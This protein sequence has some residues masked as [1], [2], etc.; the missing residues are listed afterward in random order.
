M[1]HV[2]EWKCCIS[3]KIALKFVQKVRLTNSK[4]W[5]SS[6]MHICVT[7]PQCVNLVGLQH[8]W[9]TRSWIPSGRIN[10]CWW[11]FEGQEK[12]IARHPCL[13]MYGIY[14]IKSDYLE[15][16]F[17]YPAVFVHYDNMIKT[18]VSHYRSF[19]KRIH[20]WRSDYTHKE[21]VMVICSFYIFY[22]ASLNKL[23]NKESG[24]QL[25]ENIISLQWC[26]T[27]TYLI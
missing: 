21:L 27:G 1:N 26:D 24:Y 15:S 17:V 18:H 10:R 5:A 13:C 14:Q 20:P 6:P 11:I 4:Q 8:V 9:H 2:L 12:L 23:V 25:F 7:L 22:Y 3:I 16:V 19:V